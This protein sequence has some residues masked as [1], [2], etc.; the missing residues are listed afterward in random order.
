VAVG[1]K[2]SYLQEKI[3]ALVYV[4]D[5]R[6]VKAVALMQVRFAS[7]LA[8]RNGPQSACILHHLK[9]AGQVCT[10]RGIGLF[11]EV[12]KGVTLSG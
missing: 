3:E 2:C 7:A 6:L 12:S 10:W 4:S 5:R 8:L 11:T 9:A 1:I